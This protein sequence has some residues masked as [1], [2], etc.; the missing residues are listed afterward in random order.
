VR[1]RLSWLRCESLLLESLLGE[2]SGDFIECAGGVDCGLFDSK[3]RFERKRSSFLNAS[4][5]TASRYIQHNDRV[6]RDASVGRRYQKTCEGNGRGRFKVDPF[7]LLEYLS[8]ACGLMVRD[9][10]DVA[11]RFQQRILYTPMDG[12]GRKP[13]R[14]DRSLNLTDLVPGV[15][16]REVRPISSACSPCVIDGRKGKVLT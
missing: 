6:R 10:Q 11:L 7:A 9:G 16:S 3:I 15:L 1:F 5:P 13:I 2:E 4:K 14:Q 8:G 12:I